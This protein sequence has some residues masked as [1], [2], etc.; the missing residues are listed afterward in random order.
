[1]ESTSWSSALYAKYNKRFISFCP[2]VIG[3]VSVFRISDGTVNGYQDILARQLH[4]DSWNFICLTYDESSGI[5]RSYLDGK[6]SG[7]HT[8]IPSLPACRRIV[9]GGDPFQPSFKGYISGV[10]FFNHA[11]SEEEIFNLY[12]TFGNE[13]GF[14]G[15]L[16]MF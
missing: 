15:K 16:K 4:Q 2:Y 14:C 8:D 11:K 10:L 6:N 13:P 1:L 12:Q 5:S 9:L 7:F 3:G